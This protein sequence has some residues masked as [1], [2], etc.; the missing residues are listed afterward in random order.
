MILEHKTMDLY[1]KMV[2][3]RAIVQTPFSVGNPMP[4]EACFL[5]V[6][7]GIGA[8]YSEVEFMK[9]ESGEGILMKCG[10]FLNQMLEGDEEGVYEAIAVHFYPEVLKKVYDNKMPSFLV[11]SDPLNNQEKP[12]VKLGQDQLFDKFFEGIL[13]YFSNPS[14]VNE[15]LI[16]LKLKELLLLLENTHES[17]KL[18]LILANLFSP[19]THSF[20]S[21]IESH[22]YSNLSLE[23]LA[24]LT[25][26]SLSGFKRKFKEIYKCS[27]A[28]FIREQ[29]LNRCA[30]LLKSSSLSISEI[31]FQCAFND[32]AHFSNAFKQ[33]FGCSPSEYRIS[34]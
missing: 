29:R 11:S 1:G 20:K 3:E 5:F 9:I 21:I 14:L 19:Q 22:F 33:Q 23:E 27:P 10:S 31:A 17:E 32:L 18:H 13:Y 4:D 12:S 34:N 6:R 25:S 16:E 30:E 28:K 15:E 2:F 8:A 26:H 7:K 24:T